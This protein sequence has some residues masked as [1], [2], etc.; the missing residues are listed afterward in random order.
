MFVWSIIHAK[1]ISEKDDVV[2]VSSDSDK[3]LNMAKRW[4]AVPIKRP[5]ELASDKAFTEPVMTHA[6]SKIDMELE[7]N[8]ILQSTSPLR[9]KRLMNKLKEELQRTDSLFR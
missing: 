2:L 6:I 5:K 7:D 4:G 3:Y 9:S 1:Y 8:V